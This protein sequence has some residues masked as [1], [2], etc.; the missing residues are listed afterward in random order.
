MTYIEFFDRVSSENISACLTYAP[1]R[2]IYIG[3]NSKLM[4][5]H[6]EYYDR[7]FKGRGQN[8]EFSC[9]TIPK[10]NLEKSV[11]VLTELVEAYDDCVFDINGGDEIFNVALGIVFAQNP[12]KNLQIHRFN[13]K[14]NVMCDCDKDG[15][16]VYKNAPMLTVEENI[17]IYGGDIVYGGVSEEQTYAWD[18]TR[19]FIKDIDAIW[20]VCRADP[21]LWN[22]QIGV[23]EAVEAV[24]AVSDDGLTTVAEISLIE[25]YL[26]KRKASYK[27]IRGLV[28][29][30]A[31]CGLVKVSENL[32]KLTLSYK[33]AQI[34]R[35]LTKAG[36]ALEMK[37]YAVAKGLKTEKGELVY[38]DAVNGVV[39]DW[40]GEL[41]DEETE[42]VYDTENEIDILLMH[43]V[44]PVFISCKN[45]AVGSDE[46]YK[47][48]TVA[49][50]FGG[51][52]AKKALVTASISF[53][54][55]AAE[56]LRQRAIDMGIILIENAHQLDDKA[57]SAKIKNLWND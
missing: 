47:L 28:N 56:Y 9:K 46:L 30:L 2:V 14:N 26:S 55:E 49:E 57:L 45:G 6:I 33:N 10:N 12:D 7:V 42:N 23:F 39:I 38:N 29:H 1:D 8:I 35:C 27:L 18:L 41:H 19:D 21:R 37:V 25:I 3:D 44:V 17:R 22:T 5:K 48:S 53:M 24:G 54:G 40:D 36:Q 16:T 4:N 50:R 20:S 52:Y 13:L 31:K 11:E 34:K 43:G 32:G 51:H 15:N